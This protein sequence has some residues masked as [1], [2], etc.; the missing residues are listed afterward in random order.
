VY[1][2]AYSEDVRDEWLGRFQRLVL[3]PLSQAELDSVRNEVLDWLIDPA[4]LEWFAAHDMWE[5]LRLGW[6]AIANLTPDRLRSHALVFAGARRVVAIWSPA[7]DEL[8]AEVEDLGA[9]R[10]EPEDAAAESAVRPA[11]GNVTVPAPGGPMLDELRP[12]RLERL[13]SGITLA[14]SDGYH[15]FISGEFGG[16]LPGG[17]VLKSGENGTLW[18]L[19]SPPDAAVFE[20]LE[21]VR[22][23]R[24]LLFYPSQDLPDAR[25]RFQSWI[26]GRSDVSPSLSVGDVA[27]A[28][29]PG[30][31][32]LR[33]WL[34]TKLI[35]AGWWSLVGLRIDGLEGSRLV[36]D[37]DPQRE[38][39]VRDWIAQVTGAGITESDFVRV[40]D[41]AAGYYQ[42]IRRDL[43]II[44]WQRAPEGTILPP[45][46]FPPARLQHIAEAHFE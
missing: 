14:E 25:S 8:A 13:D 44:L 20:E 24:I 23:D 31:I 38:A 42:R 4:R 37:A 27:T 29:I 9:D 10:D 41:A 36:I 6:E 15:V 21:A 43:Q 30:L 46:S 17:E 11:P 28:D 16:S 33:S 3:E 7:F 1:L 19:P 45:A 39:Y 5:G 22:P 26:G 12:V 18:V 2:P 40:R 34:E 32:V 35:E